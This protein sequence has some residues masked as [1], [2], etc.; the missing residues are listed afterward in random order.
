MTSSGIEPTTFRFGAQHLNHC[1]TAVPGKEW[2]LRNRL[3]TKEQKRIREQLN[4][5]VCP[6]NYP[7]KRRIQIRDDKSVY[8]T[9]EEAIAVFLNRRASARY[10]ELALDIP[11]RDRFSWNWSF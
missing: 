2:K 10:R 6:K 11:G 9:L 1:A 3:S 4:C 5:E 7:A 8:V